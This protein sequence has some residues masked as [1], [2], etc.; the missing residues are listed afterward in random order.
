MCVFTL[1]YLLIALLIL[2]LLFFGS[3]NY[4]FILSIPNPYTIAKLHR[5]IPLGYILCYCVLHQSLSR[6][7][8][9]YICILRHSEMMNIFASTCAV[10]LYSVHTIGSGKI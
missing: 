9:I 5:D 6:L 7:T 1:T 8:V 2:T 4:D 3:R 10:S